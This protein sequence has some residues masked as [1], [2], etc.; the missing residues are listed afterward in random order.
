MSLIASIRGRGP[1]GF[2]YGSTA[3]EVTDGLDLSGKRYLV[4]G[5][6]SG[7]G[8]ETARV[9]ALRGAEVLATCRTLEKAQAACAPLGPRARPEE[10]E[11]SE[12]SNVRKLV[13]KLGAEGKSLDGII[14]NAGIMALPK[15]TVK[16]GIELQFLTNHLGHFLLV[17]GLLPLL[18]PGGRVVV[19]SSAA[20]RAAPRVGVDFDN[21]DCSQGYRPWTFY[22]Q[23]KAANLLFAKALAKR[24]NGGRT[25]NAVHPGV[26]MTN[27]WRSMP[28]VA[29]RALGLTA[30]VF[31]KSVAE[32]A[33]TT[34][35]VATHPSL[36]TVSGEYFADCNVAK[37]TRVAR[38]PDLAERLWT[39]SEEF[40]ALHP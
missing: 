7:L 34:V 26:I 39:F 21:L 22:G 11:L 4:T 6:N 29:T 36:A 38:D 13:Q 27:L 3:A 32:G 25:A 30:S 31:L 17:T 40:A 8:T 14:C 33:A 5:S 20:H 16:Y 9:L 28:A 15:P 1:S 35:Y 12:P 18:A 19:L 10:L 24:L 23:T 37:P 2:G